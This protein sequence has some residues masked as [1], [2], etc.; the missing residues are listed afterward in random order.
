MTPLTRRVAALALAAV[1]APLG[2]GAATAAD[3]RPR[4]VPYTDS[5]ERSRPVDRRRPRRHRHQPGRGPRRRGAARCATT[6]STATASPPRASARP[7]ARSCPTGSA[8]ARPSRCGFDEERVLLTD[9]SNDR[10]PLPARLRRPRRPGL[11][12]LAPRRRPGPH[13][14]RPHSAACSPTPPRC[15]PAPRSSPPAPVARS[16]RTVAGPAGA[17][18]ALAELSSTAPRAGR[19]GRAG[20]RREAVQPCSGLVTVVA[21]APRPTASASRRARPS[22][23]GQTGTLRAKV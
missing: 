3:H 4:P 11:R 16:P 22:G 6:S 23:D 7:C 18:P 15:R 1:L 9:L 21:D 12:R 10:D 8:T 5:F 19:G 13:P 17:L 14:V 2:T 20:N